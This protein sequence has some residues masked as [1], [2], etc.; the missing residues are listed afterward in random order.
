MIFTVTKVKCLIV[1]IV[2]RV[3]YPGCYGN[4]VT[5]TTRVSKISESLQQ[6]CRK[7]PG[8]CSHLIQAINTSHHKPPMTA[9]LRLRVG[10]TLMMGL[11]QTGQPL[12]CFNLGCSENLKSVLLNHIK[13]LLNNGIDI[14]QLIIVLLN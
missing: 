2:T 1:S 3:F 11:C 14:L 4:L 9:K 6:P 5:K 8:T 10:D 7:L 12:I 13:I